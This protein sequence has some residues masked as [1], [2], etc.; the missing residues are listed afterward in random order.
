LAT[1]G[2]FCALMYW[3]DWWL[4]LLFIDDKNLSPLQYLL[5]AVSNNIRAMAN[6][7]Y[8]AGMSL[9]VAPVRMAMAV[10]AIGPIALAYVFL[11]R[12]FVRG[13]TVGAFK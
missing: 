9:P 4:P 7:P 6:S 12:F 3:N 11:Q 5:Y 1:V 13:I 2:L 10:I 8:T